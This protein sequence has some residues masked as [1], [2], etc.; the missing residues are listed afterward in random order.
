[1]QADKGSIQRCLTL[2]TKLSQQIHEIRFH[3]ISVNQPPFEDDTGSGPHVTDALTLSILKEL[4]ENLCHVS[5]LL[6]AHEKHKSQSQTEGLQ[7]TNTQSVDN[8][9]GREK[10]TVSHF[11][12]IRNTNHE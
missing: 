9:T 6:R 2:C 7:D 11:P 1:M 4:N 5:Q 3:P 10:Q 12:K 8:E